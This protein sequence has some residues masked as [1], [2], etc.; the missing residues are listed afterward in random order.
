MTIPYLINFIPNKVEGVL[1]QS[2]NDMVS[3]SLQQNVPISTINYNVGSFDD[4]LIPLSVKNITNNTNLE[5]EVL[6]DD[7]I[8]LLNASNFTGK[9]FRLIPGEIVTFTISLN[10]DVMDKTSIRENTDISIKIK[11][12]TNNG[13]VTKNSSA[14][15]LNMDFLNETVTLSTQ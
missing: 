13:I 1:C 6:L 8:F 14:T 3:V 10:K 4:V 7:T 11:N 2:I 12:V 9:K 15:M 5:I